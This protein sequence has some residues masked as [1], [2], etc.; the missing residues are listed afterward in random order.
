[1]DDVEDNE[2]EEVG[3]KKKKRKR[4]KKKKPVKED[5]ESQSPDNVPSVKEN[6]FTGAEPS[7]G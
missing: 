4:N 7:E 2:A 6:N 5:V 1:L 3:E